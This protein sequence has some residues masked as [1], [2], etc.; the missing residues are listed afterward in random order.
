MNLITLQSSCFAIG[1]AASLRSPPSS[2]LFS[3]R[4]TSCPRLLATYAASIP[5]GPPPITRIFFFS[6]ASSI[7][8]DSTDGFT[9]Q[10]IGLPNIIPVRHR[11]HPIHGRISSVFPAAALF[12]NSLS[13]KFG[14]PII[15]ISVFPFAI[16][17]SATQGSLILA[18]V[19]TGI[20]TCFLISSLA[21]A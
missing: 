14:R 19:D 11:P 5:A 9:V 1:T 2:P 15:Q 4:T 18:T 17:S 21:C 12:T 7:S 6:L 8:S 3:Q 20:F 10:L 16:N 13:H